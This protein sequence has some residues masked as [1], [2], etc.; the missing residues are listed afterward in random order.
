MKEPDSSW[1]FVELFSDEMKEAFQVPTVP[2]AQNQ[3]WANEVIMKHETAS[4]SK[5]IH[6]LSG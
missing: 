5:S 4:F 2:R 1:A 6:M 3:A